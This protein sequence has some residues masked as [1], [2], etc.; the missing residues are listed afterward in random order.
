MDRCIRRA[1]LGAVVALIGCL[2]WAVETRA[3][4]KYVELGTLGGAYSVAEAVSADGGTVVGA[5]E[6]GSASRHAFLWRAKTNEMIDLGAANPGPSTATAVNANGTV[7]VG[8][9]S[10]IDTLNTNSELPFRW[11]AGKMTLLPPLDSTPQK[12]GTGRAWGVSATGATVVGQSTSAT[13][14]LHAFLWTVGSGVIDLGAAA[15]T[16]MT[17][18]FAMSEN[19]GTVAGLLELNQPVV[20]TAGGAGMQMHVLPMPQ[21]AAAALPL[22]VNANGSLVAGAAISG[23]TWRGIIWAL[24]NGNWT[25]IGDA[26]NVS[27]YGVTGSH[28]EARAMGVGGATQPSHAL[29]A[30]LH[31]SLTLT[32]A[33]DLP[34]LTPKPVGRV[35]VNGEGVSR[36]GTA[37]AGNSAAAPD[38]P[39]LTQRAFLISG[40]KKIGGVIRGRRPPIIRPHF[41]VTC[42]APC[43]LGPPP[44]P[45]QLVIL[46][47]FAWGSAD[48][49]VSPNPMASRV[50]LILERLLQARKSRATR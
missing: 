4:P 27:F 38:A 25:I 26:D 14:D 47:Q 28:S 41:E 31:G 20:W 18:A 33:N 24:T 29:I 44:S 48:G 50:R 12:K 23:K 6:T 17:S 1:H 15:P 34:K 11:A 37:I 9:A 5:S 21:G 16:S 46:E 35:L 19:A 43:R 13:G 42:P 2:A 45:E 40:L 22:S 3:D 36:D 32:D 7:A 39:A 30:D 49:Q 8:Y 10:P